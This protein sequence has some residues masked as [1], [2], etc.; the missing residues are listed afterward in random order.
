MK[1][2]L[3]LIYL[4]L[5]S[6]FAMA[7]PQHKISA[8]VSDW[9]NIDGTKMNNTIV[10]RLEAVNFDYFIMNC[11]NACFLMRLSSTTQPVSG[12][13]D[14]VVNDSQSSSCYGRSRIPFSIEDGELKKDATKYY[15]IN[16]EG[17]KC[18]D[19]RIT[20]YVTQNT[21]PSGNWKYKIAMSS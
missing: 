1:K 10:S 20:L 3:I 6:N 16:L 17:T 21:S 15:F 8:E 13:V 11:G 2:Y 19:R 12:A 5:F 4:I 18:R 14:I 7:A 9:I